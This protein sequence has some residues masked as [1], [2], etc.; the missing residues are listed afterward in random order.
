LSNQEYPFHQCSELSSKL[1]TI[2]TLTVRWLAKSWTPDSFRFIACTGERVE[3]L[4]VGKL[5]G[6]A[7]TKT[8]DYEVKHAKGLGNE[9]RCY[10]NFECEAWKWVELA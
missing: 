6:G 8:T 9:W 4:I 10:S 2:A 7:A 5:Y 3:S 1:T